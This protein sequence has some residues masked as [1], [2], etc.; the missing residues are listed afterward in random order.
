MAATF[1]WNVGNN[2][3]THPGHVG[4]YLQP[5]VKTFFC[6]IP[7]FLLL[8]AA[9]R[10]SKIIVSIFVGR[11]KPQTA[12][13]CS[14]GTLPQIYGPPSDKKRTKKKNILETDTKQEVLTKQIPTDVVRRVIFPDEKL[15]KSKIWWPDGFQTQSNKWNDLNR[16]MTKAR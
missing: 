13:T 2:T 11:I 8:S 15:M 14:A 16:S 10:K 7:G 5:C 3:H 12:Q 9:R 1:G 6:K 4:A